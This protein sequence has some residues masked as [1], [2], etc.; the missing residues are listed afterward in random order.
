[1]QLENEDYC[2]NE[3]YNERISMGIQ[4]DTLVYKVGIIAVLICG[5][6]ILH[7]IFHIAYM[8]D[9]KLYGRMK[10]LGATHRQ[11]RNA[12]S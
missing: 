2:I 5:F 1:M 11:I 10:I 4:Q 7:S 6:L 8:T 3:V 9:M 12:V